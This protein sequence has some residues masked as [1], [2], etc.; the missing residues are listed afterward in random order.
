MRFYADKLKECRKNITTQ[1]K[2][3]EELNI[4]FEHYTKVEKGYNNPSVPLF[5]KICDTLDRPAQY[6]FWDKEMHLSKSQFDTLM[7]YD[8]Q[9]LALLL[10]LLQQLYEENKNSNNT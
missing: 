3:S 6:F 9:K 1:Q 8:D 2:F 7:Q 4:S 10:H 5:I